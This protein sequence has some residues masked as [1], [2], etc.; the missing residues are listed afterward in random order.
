RTHDDRSSFEIEVEHL[1]D[2]AYDVLIDGVVKGT[3]VV[4]GG[5]GEIEFESGSDDGGH[6]L[7]FDP[8]G[9]LVQVRHAT[10]IVLSATGLAPAPGVSTCTPSESE[11]PLSNVGPD[12]DASGSVRVQ[13]ADDC[14]HDF[15]VEIEDL[16]VG[17]YDLLVGGILRGSIAVSV[18]PDG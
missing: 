17:S 14:G 6:A 10:T 15:R 11:T 7:D 5:V 2:G 18:R 16:P 9:P 4:S 13:V 3:L 8:L 12:V 1:A